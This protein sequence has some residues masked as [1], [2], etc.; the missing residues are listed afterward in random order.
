MKKFKSAIALLLAVL[1]FVSCFATASATTASEETEDNN[2]YEKVDTFEIGKEIKGVLAT[3]G[4]IDYFTFKAAKTGLA[5]LTFKHNAVAGAVGSYF[6]VKAEDSGK[7]KVAEITSAGTSTSDTVE[8][9]VIANASYYVVIEKGVV[10]DT[11]L[12]Y[13]FNVAV[14]DSITSETEPNNTADAATALALTVPGAAPKFYYGSVGVGED[15]ADFYKIAV[16]KNGVINLYLYNDFSPKSN[17][18]ATLKTYVEGSDGTQSLSAVTSISMTAAEASKIGPSVCVPA[19]NYFLVVEGEGSY[20]TRA[21]FREASG[22]ETEINDSAAQ[23]D[24][25]TIGTTYKATIDETGDTDYFEFTAPADNKGFD[26]NFK[27]TSNGQWNVRLLNTNKEAIAETLEVKATAASK[28]AKLETKPLAAG[29]YYI[30]VKAGTEFNSDIYE[31]SV[32]AKEK[33]IVPEPE[34]G[35]FDK[36]GDLDWG[37]LWDN[38]SGWIEEIN[39]F[40]MLTS[41]FSSILMGLT[42]LFSSGK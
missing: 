23:A 34:K 15:K 11:T 30:E 25:I 28:T 18:T 31:I 14:D 36:I 27:A 1:M 13:T 5:K 10:C 41:M 12:N 9:L 8:F 42:L 38:F 7:N 22:T 35:L 16:P 21:Y 32:T 6:T 37:A 20:R 24:K 29:T 39:F 33:S 2:S 19:G 17:V 40:G 4:D 26:I 3:E